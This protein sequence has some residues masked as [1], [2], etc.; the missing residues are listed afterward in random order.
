MNRYEAL[1]MFNPNFE[2]ESLEQLFASVEAVVTNNKGTLLRVDR[3][4][5]KK[6]S[7]AMQKNREAIISV[8][9]FDAPPQAIA[10]IT[11]SYKLNESILRYTIVRNDEI[12]I[13]KPAMVTPVTG[14]E[15]REPRQGRRPG[16]RMG[17]PRRRNDGEEFSHEQ[18]ESAAE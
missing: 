6:L 15:M 13:N 16:G 14:R 7:Y 17:G 11:H 5:R 18:Q 8:M 3:I 12:D 10:A 4:G 9:V 1:M 2:Q